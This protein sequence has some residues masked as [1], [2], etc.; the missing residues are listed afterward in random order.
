MEA[1]SYKFGALAECCAI[2][3]FLYPFAAVVTIKGAARI[4][5]QDAST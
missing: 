2:D 4:K 1:V 3:C 5:R